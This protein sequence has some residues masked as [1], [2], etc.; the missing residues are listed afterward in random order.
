VSQLAV[1]WAVR[2]RHVATVVFG[3]SKP[4][5][6]AEQ[7]AALELVPKLTDEVMVRIEAACGTH[8]PAPPI[9]EGYQYR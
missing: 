5:R 4:S 1:A 9:N 8:P 6:I 7:V 2:N 3:T